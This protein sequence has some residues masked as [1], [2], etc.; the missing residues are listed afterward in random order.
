L[1]PALGFGL[2][3]T[4]GFQIK[5]YVQ[6][7]HLENTFTESLMAFIVKIARLWYLRQS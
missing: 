4:V 5:F 6:A 2:A 1:A 7:E 3:I